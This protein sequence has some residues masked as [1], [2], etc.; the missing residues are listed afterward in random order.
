MGH[1]FPSLRQ[2]FAKPQ[3]LVRGSMF[4]DRQDP[5]GVSWAQKQG[6]EQGL[7]AV[8][9]GCPGERMVLGGGAGGWLGGMQNATKGVGR[10]AG[11]VGSQRV[12]AAG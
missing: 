2:P 6:R 7:S 3:R 12:A 9:C 4:P 5:V 8:S 1:G 10:P 11:T